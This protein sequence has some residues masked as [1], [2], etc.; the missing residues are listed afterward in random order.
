MKTMLALLVSTAL[1]T[2][3]LAQQR[4]QRPASPP[5]TQA[6]APAP[7]PPA[8]VYE[9]LMLELS[10]IMGALSI[11][12]DVCRKPGDSGPFGEAW[13]AKMAGLIDVE[14]QT[15]GMRERLAGAYNRGALTY[16]TTYRACTPAGRVALERLLADGARIAAEINSRFGT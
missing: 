12:S 8:P 5:A 7:E 15:A 2:T 4:P 9:P 14:A 13:R 1:A 3:A 16:R 6:P 10:E 11:M